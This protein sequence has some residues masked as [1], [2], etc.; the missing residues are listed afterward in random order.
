[1][2]RV[3]VGDDW[4]LLCPWLVAQHR[5]GVP[6]WALTWLAFYLHKASCGSCCLPGCDPCYRVKVSLSCTPGDPST[7]L[8]PAVPVTVSYILPAGE[9]VIAGGIKPTISVESLQ[10]LS[11]VEPLA[12]GEWQE[13]FCMSA[14]TREPG[15]R[16]GC[17][18][19]SQEITCVC[20]SERGICMGLC[21]PEPQH[22]WTSHEML[23]VFAMPGSVAGS[24]TFLQPSI[25]CGLS[26]G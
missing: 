19:C 4:H 3:S 5:F 7:C 15:G 25:T 17:R 11:E 12:A 16:Y 6:G 26:K 8:V 1:M 10:L 14:G 13:I 24:V 22:G 2:P 20:G 21:V 18:G 23:F 9:V